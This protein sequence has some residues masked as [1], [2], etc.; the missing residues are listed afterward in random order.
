VIAAAFGVSAALM[1]GA[2]A[3]APARTPGPLAPPVSF[4]RA[5][6]GA[7]E[8]VLTVPRVR[9]LLLVSVI[10]EVFGFSY[11]TAVPLAA[12]DILFTGAAGLGIL[13][14][15]TA[16]GGT[17]ALIG[18]AIL[19][20]RVAREPILGGVFL[21]YGLALCALAF[22]RDLPTAAAVLLLI[23]A[24]AAAFDLLQQLLMQLAVPD[25]QRGRAVGLWV[26]GIG[27]APLGHLEM[28]ALAGA[29]GVPLALL[30]NGTVL[31]TAA[32]VLAVRAP[33]FRGRLAALR[34]T[35]ARR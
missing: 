5:M 23:G 35:P 2:R 26:V 21:L 24:C 33:A 11:L 12:R 19:P 4:A 10:C 29:V 17:A 34:P 9:L 6:R 8:L 13:N 15:A 1:V 30:V 18:L 28:G 25:A 16:I 27:S 32:G 14:A 7:G 20:G 31:T 3:P 22:C